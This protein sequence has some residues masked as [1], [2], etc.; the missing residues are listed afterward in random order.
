MLLDVGNPNKFHEFFHDFSVSMTLFV[1]FS[2]HD[3]GNPVRRTWLESVEAEMVEL[4]INKEYVH[5]GKKWRRNVM[6]RK[7][8]PIGKRTINR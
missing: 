7:S 6:K 1:F 3:C 5:D 2:F 8:N 4:E